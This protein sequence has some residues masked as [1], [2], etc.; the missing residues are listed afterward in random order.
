[1]IDL[2]F[3]PLLSFLRAVYFSS[4]RLA[5]SI[6][7]DGPV[8]RTRLSPQQ[9]LNYVHRFRPQGTDATPAALAKQL[10]CAGDSKRMARGHT[11]SASWI[12]A[13]V[14]YRNASNA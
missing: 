7:E 5:L 12:L 11:S 10:T 14:L 6:D 13:P 1:M 3:C 8:V 4:A 2:R 9:R